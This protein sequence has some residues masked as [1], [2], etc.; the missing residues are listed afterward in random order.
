MRKISN[1]SPKIECAK[2]CFAE[3]SKCAK[4]IEK[5]MAKY[6]VQLYGDH[7]DPAG[8]IIY[9]MFNMCIPDD[10][11]ASSYKPSNFDIKD[12]AGDFQKIYTRKKK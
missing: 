12:L 1:P 9:S 10:E 3:V 7:D 2:L 11:K 6:G 4:R 5:A 8:A